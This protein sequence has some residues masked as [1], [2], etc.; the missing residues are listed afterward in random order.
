M[1]VDRASWRSRAGRLSLSHLLVSY[2]RAR[3]VPSSPVV[4]DWAE[5]QEGGQEE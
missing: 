2:V 3:G 5:E 1:R 4:N